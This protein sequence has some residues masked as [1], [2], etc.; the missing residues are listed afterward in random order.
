MM[1]MNI[2]YKEEYRDE[3]NIWTLWSVFMWSVDELEM[4][5]K[6]DG[7]EKIYLVVDLMEIMTMTMIMMMMTMMMVMVIMMIIMMRMIMT[8]YLAADLME[9][10]AS[11]GADNCPGFVA[12]SAPLMDKIVMMVMV[13]VVMVIVMMLVI[14]MIVMMVMVVMMV[15]RSRCSL[16]SSGR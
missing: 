11:G 9:S 4:L 2:E 3:K 16:S 5:I 14:M 12:V 8:I 15:S 10:P 6:K 13:M 1:R 7:E